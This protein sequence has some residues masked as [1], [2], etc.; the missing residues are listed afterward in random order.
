MEMCKRVCLVR[1]YGRRFKLEHLAV[2][3]NDLLGFI[4]IFQRLPPII[5]L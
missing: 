2:E 3:V 1:V 5:V 4:S